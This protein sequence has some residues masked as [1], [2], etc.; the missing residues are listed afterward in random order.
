MVYTCFAFLPSLT[1]HFYH[2]ILYYHSRQFLSLNRGDSLL[3]DIDPKSINLFSSL[4]MLNDPFFY[5]SQ[6]L[7][8][9]FRCDTRTATCRGPYPANMI[10]IKTL[11][12]VFNIGEIVLISIK[13]IYNFRN[14]SRLVP[15]LL[16]AKKFCIIFS[17]KKDRGTLCI[18]VIL[19][20]IRYSF[21]GENYHRTFFL[22][23]LE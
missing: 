8:H 7:F 4:A 20:C 15:K 6:H 11:I 10:S 18:I 2:P 13:W 19:I 14:F 22:N 3:D 16:I 9:A 21:D 1:W 12:C 17:Y 5:C 23:I